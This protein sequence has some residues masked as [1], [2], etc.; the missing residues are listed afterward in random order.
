MHSK[1]LLEKFPFD[2]KAT[3]IEDRIWS[4]QRIKQGYKIFY[5]SNASVY[6]WHGINQDNNKQRLSGVV[7]IL[8]ENNL[9]F[10]N[11][12][13]RKKIILRLQLFLR[14]IQ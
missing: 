12:K 7:R 4:T 14:W 9:V 2:E 13:A 6:H 3:N 8:E 5:N 11:L 10:P 1:K